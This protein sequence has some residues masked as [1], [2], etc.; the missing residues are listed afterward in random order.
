MPTFRTTPIKLRRPMV[1]SL[2]FNHS[3]HILPL[4]SR[5]TPS[6]SA[7]RCLQQIDLS[8]LSIDWRF[9]N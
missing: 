8:K 1:A 2:P 9:Q 5:D 6:A 4:L 7:A 3:I